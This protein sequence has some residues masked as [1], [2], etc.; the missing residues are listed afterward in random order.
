MCRHSDPEPAP[1]D[2]EGVAQP[3]GE[4]G[5]LLVGAGGLAR[6]RFVQVGESHRLLS[7]HERPVVARR[8]GELGRAR[9]LRS[10]GAGV[11]ELIALPSRSA[12]APRL[13][14]SPTSSASASASVA[15]ASAA[16]KSPTQRAM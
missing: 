1:G 9:E 5:D 8:P 2:L 10:P 4:R 13:P 16:S 6:V 15:Y 14:W 12:P 7:R 11:R 3:L